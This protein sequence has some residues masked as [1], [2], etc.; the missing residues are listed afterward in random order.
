MCSLIVTK[1]GLAIALNWQPLLSLPAAAASGG[2][3]PPQLD[4]ARV[5]VEKE[6][7]QVFQERHLR[8]AAN[9]V[10]RSRG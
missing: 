10:I 3:R 9:D 6:E 4:P 1:N 2:P 5:H 8:Y 7:P